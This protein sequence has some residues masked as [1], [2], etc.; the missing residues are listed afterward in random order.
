MPKPP[1]NPPPAFALIACRVLEA[2]IAALS[3]E[4]THF[5][6]REFFEI[7]LHDQLTGLRSLLAG[8]TSHA[9]ESR[10]KRLPS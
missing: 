5:V 10:R 8:S 2:E 6:R 3:Q 9:E 7:G 4:A 1:A